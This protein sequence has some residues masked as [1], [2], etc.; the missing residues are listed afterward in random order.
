MSGLLNSHRTHGSAW[1]QSQCFSERPKPRIKIIK[2]LMT[3]NTICKNLR[4]PQETF[5]KNES[6]QLEFSPPEREEVGI[7]SDYILIKTKVMAA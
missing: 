4:I 5:Y 1:E 7:I 3:I 2:A 6:I